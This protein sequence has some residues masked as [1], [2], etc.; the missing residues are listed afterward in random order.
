MIASPLQSAALAAA[1][2]PPLPVLA[3]A[4]TIHHLEAAVRY[5]SS[6]LH[7]VFQQ[8]ATMADYSAAL[9]YQ[10]D[11]AMAQ[12]LLLNQG[13]AAA[14]PVFANLL[15]PIQAG[16]Q[17]VQAGLQAVQAGQAGGQAGLQAVQAGLQGVQVGLQAVRDEQAVLR[18]SIINTRSRAV[19]VRLPPHNILSVI[20]KE[21]AGHPAGVFGV[22]GPFAIGDQP[23]VGVIPI[24]KDQIRAINQHVALDQAYWFYNDPILAN[25]AQSVSD[26]RKILEEFLGECYG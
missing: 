2:Q 3:A 18:V 26:R 7:L 11:V 12:S 15:A 1:L 4:A 14:L 5:T 20:R 16:L 19:N 9:L 22:G 10:N 24:S 8:V 17:G 25:A 23:P 6:I 13:F 21:I